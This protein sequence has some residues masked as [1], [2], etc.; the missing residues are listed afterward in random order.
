MRRETLVSL[1]K[2]KKK[3]NGFASR[4]FNRLND[5]GE[6]P[7]RNAS[8]SRSTE[9]CNLG[10]GRTRIVNKSSGKS[11]CFIEQSDGIALSSGRLGRFAF[12]GETESFL[13]IQAYNCPAIRIRCK[14]SKL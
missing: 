3:K 9:Q 7:G 10:R 12:G 5:G 13:D 8:G 4:M 1:R 11:Y 2:K 6:R 14:T